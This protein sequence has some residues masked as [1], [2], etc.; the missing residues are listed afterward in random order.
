MPNR[1]SVVW[2]TGHNRWFVYYNK[3]GDYTFNTKHIQYPVGQITLVHILTSKETKMS[4][5][6][7]KVESVLK[8]AEAENRLEDKIHLTFKRLESIFYKRPDLVSDV[9]ESFNFVVQNE[10][11]TDGTLRHACDVLVRIFQNQPDLAP[12]VF[13]SFNFV[14]QNEKN[15]PYSLNHAYDVLVRIFQNQPDLAPKVFDTF[16]L[17]LKHKKNTESSFN[18][19]RYV[20]KESIYKQP[21]VLGI[22]NSLLQNKK[23]DSQFLMCTYSVF[24][25]VMINAPRFF[26]SAIKKDSTF[27]HDM[28]KLSKSRLKNNNL[29]SKTLDCLQCYVSLVCEKRPVYR[30]ESFDIYKE[31]LQHK[32]CD[33]DVLCQVGKD[34]SD[35]ATK[36]TP[37]HIPDILKLLKLGSQ[38]KNN[39]EES[40]RIICQ[41][42]E[43]IIEIQSSLQPEVF[44]TVK[45]V[46]QSKYHND[47]SLRTVYILLSNIVEEAQ[48]DLTPKVLELVKIGLQNDKN[49]HYAL[50]E[51]SYALKDIVQTRPDLTPKAFEL[52]KAVIQNDKHDQDSL[53]RVYDTLGSIV[54]AQPDLT[55]D[56]IEV[57][58]I[59]LQ[60]DKNNDSSLRDAYDTLGSIVKAQPDL[61]PDV[62]E[63]FKIGLQ[64]DKNS[65]Y[66]LSGVY[67]ALGSIVK[68]QVDLAPKAFEVIKVGLQN[69]KNNEF[70]LGDAYETLDSIV[71]AQPDLAPN[72]FEVVKVGLQ[73]KYNTSY[74]LEKARNTLKEIVKQQPDL[75]SEMMKTLKSESKNT[76]KKNNS[77]VI[78]NK[79]YQNSKGKE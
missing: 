52:V 19:A 54:K 25:D 76:D 13:E 22:L 9:F 33:E 55:P 75:A 49:G 1:T 6:K 44:E 66:S 36:D 42:L 38:H 77:N 4:E 11:N 20:L 3:K 53:S 30:D 16:S 17:A 15:T 58:K 43:K 62:I 5:L 34:L 39:G 29:D 69:D 40:F 27:A 78:L 24:D 67:E 31:I 57:F 72:V 35:F 45:D 60:N 18:E 56:V 28:L 63:V 79:Y 71:E 50:E 41:T 37:H 48:P 47:F 26:G 21:S 2:T 46:L 59:G 23:N 8:K 65:Y 10:E 32:N 12:K 51:A 68:T 14:V 64:N 70:S 7:E 73:H 74:S 61:T